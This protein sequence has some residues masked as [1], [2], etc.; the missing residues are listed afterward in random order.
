MKRALLVAS[1][2]LLAAQ[3][4]RAQDLDPL[5]A[6]ITRAWNQADAGEIASLASSQGVSL[7]ISGV[8][9]GPL[10]ARQVA[11]ALRKLFESLETVDARA[12][13]H[14]E[15]AGSPRRAFIEVTW[16]T[17][18]RGTTQPEQSKVFLGLTLEDDAWRVTEIRHIK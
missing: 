13:I 17:R 5:V 4:V 14:R 8:Q 16:T 18:S 3:S 6:H 10:S 12:G 7:Q 11:A 9:V 1:G 15:L 2:I